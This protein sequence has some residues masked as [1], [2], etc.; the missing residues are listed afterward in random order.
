MCICHIA[1]SSTFLGHRDGNPREPGE[2]VCLRPTCRGCV[3]KMRSGDGSNPSSQ[4]TGLLSS[5][6]VRVS[7]EKE[8][9]T[10]G[11][12]PTPCQAAMVRHR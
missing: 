4:V 5:P 6:L 10:F 3:H 2:D 1:L 12:K 7:F 11:V 9:R 8:A